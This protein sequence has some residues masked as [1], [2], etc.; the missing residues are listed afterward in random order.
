VP[1]R[2]CPTFRVEGILLTAKEREGYGCGVALQARG[3]LASGSRFL[4]ITN[5]STTTT[6]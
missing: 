5:A 6:A 1:T 3:P 2:S 4:I